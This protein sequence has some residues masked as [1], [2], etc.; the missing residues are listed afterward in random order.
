MNNFVV[1]EQT[2]KPLYVKGKLLK[3]SHFLFRE[4]VSYM[5]VQY[6]YYIKHACV[7][8]S[9]PVVQNKSFCQSWLKALKGV[10][11]GLGFKI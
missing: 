9:A 2:R 10:Y 3:Q 8:Y 1:K 7:Q 11:D 6:T 4:T 5:H